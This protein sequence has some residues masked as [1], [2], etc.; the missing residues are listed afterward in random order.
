MCHIK[1]AFFILLY[2]QHVLAS[3]HRTYRMGISR[4]QISLTG[5]NTSLYVMM[6]FNHEVQPSLGVMAQEHGHICHHV[7]VQC[8]SLHFNCSLAN[9]LGFLRDYPAIFPL[10]HIHT[11]TH[12]HRHARTHMHAHARIYLCCQLVLGILWYLDI[13][14]IGLNSLK[15]CY[16][17]VGLGR[18]CNN[19]FQHISAY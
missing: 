10:T 12:T 4:G 14:S 15:S 3:R 5:R 2:C 7:E 9:C 6:D 8:S 17:F 16:L 13:T 19:I 11:S 18:R 1:N